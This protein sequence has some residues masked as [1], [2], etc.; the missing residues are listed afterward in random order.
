MASRDG[1]TARLPVAPSAAP[2]DVDLGHD[3]GGAPVALYSHCAGGCRVYRVGL[4]GGRAH[5]L[6][7]RGRSPS[8][9]GGRI[10]YRRGAWVMLGRQRL[11]RGVAGAIETELDY[12]GAHVVERWTRVVYACPGVPDFAMPTLESLLVVATPDGARR[13]LVRNCL[14]APGPPS[15]VD[16]AVVAS[17][18]ER[19]RRFAPDGPE[20]AP[21]AVTGFDGASVVAATAGHVYARA[22]DGFGGSRLVDAGRLPAD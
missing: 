13:T 19:L 15:L 4:A 9:W 22:P 8:Q 17:M 18:G 7:L 1:T 10:A 3:A 2:F 6:A 12:D 5:R 21:A 16:G 14:P 11:H 20:P